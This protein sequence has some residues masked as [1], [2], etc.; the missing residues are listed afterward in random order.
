[1]DAPCPVCLP[2]GVS[3]LAS[4][5]RGW[6][7]DPY[8][9]RSPTGRPFAAPGHLR[10]RESDST[11]AETCDVVFAGD[12]RRSGGSQRALL[13]EIRA[14]RQR[15]LRIGVMHMEAFRFMTT[16]R[17]PLPAPIQELV[18]SGKIAHCLP[19]ERRRVPLLIVRDP[20]CLQFAPGQPSRLEVG[21]VIVVANH[22]PCDTDGQDLRY[23]PRACTA[24]V[25]QLFSVR[26]LWLPQGPQVRRSL[27]ETGMGP[28]ELSELDMRP[29][30]DPEVWRLERNGFRAALPIV[31]FHYDAG[32]R[33]AQAAWSAVAGASGFADIDVRIMG[34]PEGACALLGS[35]E[36]PWNWMAYEHD[37]ISIRSFLFQIDFWA[38]FPPPAWT[39]EHDQAI[40]EAL[41]AGCVVILPH[42][43][44][45]VRGRCRLLPPQRGRRDH[46]RYHSNPELFAEQSA[47]AQQR[48]RTMFGQKEYSELVSRLLA[49]AAD[50][51]DGRPN[52]LASWVGTRRG[53]PIA[54]GAKANEI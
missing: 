10:N 28:L 31:G 3:P 26:P 49:G 5:D 17:E 43:F 23:V 19:T 36:L 46:Q 22:A 12:L 48:V 33:K 47:L 11:E 6:D 24:A 53:A 51:G 42:R 2:V 14:L 9:A 15:G 52:A 35:T 40:L 25:E 34:G 16:K 18:N 20:L 8:L 32:R 27:K 54:A 7:A 21:R 13:E 39:E 4:P 29:V 1:M 41:A 30:I 38:Y 50:S 44:A 37:E 45:D